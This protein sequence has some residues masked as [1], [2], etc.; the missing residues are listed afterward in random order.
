VV[1]SRT[2]IREVPCSIPGASHPV[3]GSVVFLHHQ[4]NV[5]VDP[6]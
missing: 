3:E 4:A 5:G 2:R 1:T 6:T